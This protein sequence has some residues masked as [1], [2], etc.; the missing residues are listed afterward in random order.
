M[1]SNILTFPVT[2]RHANQFTGS[3][4]YSLKYLQH[5]AV[6]TVHENSLDGKISEQL[7]LTGPCT[8]AVVFSE[9][10]A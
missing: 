8:L 1:S 2:H 10:E 9:G 7:Q 5:L 4:P 3:L 6:L